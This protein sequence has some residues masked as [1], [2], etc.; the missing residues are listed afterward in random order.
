MFTKNYPIDHIRAQFPSLERVYNGN[1]VV[2]N[3]DTFDLDN[4][5]EIINS[6][7][8]IVAYST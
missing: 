8:K 3:L 7:T 5:D 1:Q 2:L 6:K 4:M